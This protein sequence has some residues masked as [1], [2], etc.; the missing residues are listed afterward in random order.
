MGGK[1][2]KGFVY[3]D[4]YGYKKPADFKYWLDRCIQFNPMAKSSKKKK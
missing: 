3:V 1:S 4:E 2:M